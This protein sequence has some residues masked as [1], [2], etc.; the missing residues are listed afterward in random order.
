MLWTHDFSED[1]DL[2]DTTTKNHP[3][4]ELV[5][6]NFSDDFNF[7]L[8]NLDD[9]NDDLLN[10]E[11][12]TDSFDNLNFDNEFASNDDSEQMTTAGGISFTGL[13]DKETDEWY[14]P[15]C[16]CRDQKKVI[17]TRRTCGY[18]GSHHWNQGKTEE[19][20]NRVLH[21]D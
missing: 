2:P 14:C 18:L 5:E 1:F 3:E 6:T 17:P 19:I 21:V 10:S 9:N 7:D 15:Q 13:Y 11:L 4:N 8:D 12:E 16:G 20:T